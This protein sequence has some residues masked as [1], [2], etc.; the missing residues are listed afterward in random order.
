[1][2]TMIPLRIIGICSNVLFFGYGYSADLIPIVVLHGCLLPL[3]LLRLQQALK[4]KQRIH[5]IA[6]SDFNVDALLPFMNERTFA[7]GAYVFRQG[8]EA[9]DIYYLVQGRAKIVEIDMD[10]GPG[11]L[12]GE[13]AMF[14]PQRQRTQSVLCQEDCRF[15]YI[16]EDKIL[17]LYSDNPEFGLYLIKMIVARLLSNANRSPLEIPVRN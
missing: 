5:E 17:Q 16:S 7:D 6:H 9:H 13:I 3:N 14:A 10:I 8:E 12:I 2:K 11:N 1:M 15:L 4:L